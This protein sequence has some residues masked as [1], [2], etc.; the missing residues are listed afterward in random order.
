MSL[1]S[2]LRDRYRNVEAS[3]PHFP[4]TPQPLSTSGESEGRRQFLPSSPGRTTH[5][6]PTSAELGRRRRR[7]AQRAALLSVLDEVNQIVA[8]YD[9][10]D[11]IDNDIDDDKVPQQ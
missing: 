2:I 6:E 11:D 7:Q 5:H 3:A 9:I 1:V 8:D 4:S 10:D